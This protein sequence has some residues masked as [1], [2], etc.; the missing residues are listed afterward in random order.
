MNNPYGN[1]CGSNYENKGYSNR[2]QH[3]NNDKYK[4]A[5]CRNFMQQGDCSYGQKCRY[6]HGEQE[7]RQPGLSMNQQQGFS[8]NGGFMPMQQP[9][10]FNDGGYGGNQAGYGGNRPQGI[11]RFFREQGQCKF[12]ENCKFS[13]DLM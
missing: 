5:L 8:G 11:C 2:P 12:G 7:V 1:S 3:H 9:N 6:A 4:T 13:H 10:N